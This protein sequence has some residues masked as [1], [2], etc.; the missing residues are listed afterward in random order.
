MDISTGRVYPSRQAAIDAGVP[1]A[2]VVEFRQTEGGELEFLTR[3]EA[4]RREQMRE[5]V[6]K[7][8]EVPAKRRG[9]GW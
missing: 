1:E 2:D 3:M 6:D 4:S 5:F 7:L 8:A 9:P